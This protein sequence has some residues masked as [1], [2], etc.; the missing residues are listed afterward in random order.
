MCP[1]SFERLIASSTSRYRLVAAGTSWADAASSCAAHSQDPLGAT[2]LVVLSTDSER[3]EITAI[4]NGR[5]A[6]IGLSDR[7]D[8]DVAFRWVTAETAEIV[9]IKSPLWAAGSPDLAGAG[10]VA[11][12]S[13][14]LL[15]ET[16]CLATN[17]LVCECDVHL[18]VPANR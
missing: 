16:D 9:E 4:L 10:C 14:G 5:T 15:S 6:W 11:L 1:S 13:N 8:I 7:V 17:F 3:T 12:G 18:D 2:H